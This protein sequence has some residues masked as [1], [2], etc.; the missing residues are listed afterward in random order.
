MNFVAIG[1]AGSLSLG[2]LSARADLEVSAS[3]SIHAQSDFYTP[4]SAQGQW[5][6]EVGLC[7]DAHRRRN[8]QICACAQEA[9]AQAARQP[10]GHEIHARSHMSFFRC[11][12]V[13]AA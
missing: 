6:V 11:F 13:V 9:Q 12:E 10:D 3:V 4:L 8:F 1:L 5:R 7:V 2:L